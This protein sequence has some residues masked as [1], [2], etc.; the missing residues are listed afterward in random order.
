MKNGVIGLVMVGFLIVSWPCIAQSPCLAVFFRGTD[1]GCYAHTSDG[2]R[3]I[4][5]EHIFLRSENRIKTAGDAWGTLSFPFGNLT[6]RPN[7]EIKLVSGGLFLETGSY[8]AFIRKTDQGF[9]FQS[10]S[11]TLGVR[12]TVFAATASGGVQVDQGAVLRRT[13]AGESLCLAGNSEG[14][15]DLLRASS[16]PAIR[17]LQSVEDALAADHDGK[18]DAAYDTWKE[19]WL[20]APPEKGSRAVALWLAFNGFVERREAVR[21]AANDE[22]VLVMAE[23]LLVVGQATATRELLHGVA[24]RCGLKDLSPSHEPME[25]LLKRVAEALADQR[26]RREILQGAPSLNSSF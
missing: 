17:A 20:A 12:G 15:I 26:L 6:V 14:D 7:T 21:L 16:Q 18:S 11:A 22:E 13:E 3:P 23:G 8:K 9:R 2:W 10:P 25:T 24:R 1:A 19:L 4:Q 5:K